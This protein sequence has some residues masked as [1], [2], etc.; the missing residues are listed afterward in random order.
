MTKIKFITVAIIV[1]TFGLS[2]TLN[3]PN[4]EANLGSL[5]T[6]NEDDPPC[7]QMY[8][9]IEKYSEEYKIPRKYAYGVAYAETRY[10]GPFDW[11]YNHAQTSYA[12]ALGPMQIM[13]ATAKLINGR[14]IPNSTLKSDIE[15]NV[16]TSMKLLRRLKNKY[17]DWKVVFG[18]YNTGRPIVND[19]AHKVYNY[20]PQWAPTVVK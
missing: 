11:K 10:R 7:L 8:Y 16:E 1:L 4:S 5:P 9:Y 19:Y 18:C 3:A 17:G 2:L 15:L 20:D 6:I 14:P 13:P 12:G